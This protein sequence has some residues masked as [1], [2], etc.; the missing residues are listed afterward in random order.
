MPQIGWKWKRRRWLHAELLDYAATYPLD[1]PYTPEMLQGM[2]QD[3]ERRYISPTTVANCAR[4][5]HLQKTRDYYVDVHKAWHA[6]RGT[7][8]HLMMEKGLNET[9]A[10]LEIKR[11]RLVTL[12][13]GR[14][15]YLEGT[16]DKLLPSQNKILDYKSVKDKDR[17][18]PEIIEKKKKGWSQ[19]LS[20]YR[21]MCA[22]PHEWFD[23][24]AAT[25]KAKELGRALT[26]VE[27][28]AFWHPSEAIQ[29]DVATIQLISM[30][31]ASRVDL[32]LWPLARI[33]GWLKSRMPEFVRVRD[34]EVTDDTLPR[35]LIEGIDDLAYLC[36][37][38]C[39]VGEFC[40]ALAADGK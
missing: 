34:G 2:L 26:S 12:H 22:G 10:I 15:V 33:E 20:C 38:W 21:W 14:Q 40:R 29:I 8:A 32:E 3:E 11:R 25:Y 17:V 24:E 13:D 16:P 9:D 35:I 1:F 18:D 19:Q 31:G 36:K 39:A 37:N 23:G 4:K 28:E 7:I 6:Y 27:A 30:D 5:W